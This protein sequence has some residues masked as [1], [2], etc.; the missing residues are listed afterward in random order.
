MQSV[1]CVSTL[2]EEDSARGHIPFG[3]CGV[4]QAKM[5]ARMQAGTTGVASVK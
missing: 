5:Q 2:D 3:A 4:L 1:V